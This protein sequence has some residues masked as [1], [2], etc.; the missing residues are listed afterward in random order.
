MTESE[1]VAA[2]DALTTEDPEA[3]HIK[4]EDT[5]LALVPEAVRVAFERAASRVGF[6]YA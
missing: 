3:A 6:W 5:L 1:A 4:A 2:L